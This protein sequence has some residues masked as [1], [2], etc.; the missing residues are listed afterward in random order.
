ML[1][2]REAPAMQPFADCAENRGNA[3]LFVIFRPVTFASKKGVLRLAI[4]GGL[5]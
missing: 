5:A 3:Q 4:G 1:H 2:C